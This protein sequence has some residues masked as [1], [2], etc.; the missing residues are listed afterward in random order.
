MVHVVFDLKCEVKDE[1]KVSDLGEGEIDSVVDA[2]ILM[3]F[4][5][6]MLSHVSRRNRRMELLMVLNDELR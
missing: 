5:S 2:K 6:V 3:D 1:S 4:V